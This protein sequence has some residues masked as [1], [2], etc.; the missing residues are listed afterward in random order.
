[1]LDL[2]TSFFWGKKEASQSSNETYSE[3]CISTLNSGNEIDQ[4]RIIFF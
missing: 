4:V 3:Y 2:V 1:M